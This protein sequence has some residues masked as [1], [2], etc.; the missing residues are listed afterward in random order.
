VPQQS[1]VIPGKGVAPLA[2]ILERIVG[3]IIDGLIVGIP[4]LIVY[5]IV[6]A[7]FLTS[8][9]SQITVD[10]VTGEI[11]SLGTAGPGFFVTWLLLFLIIF[12]AQIL[13][14]VGLI[15]TR[16]QTVGGMIMKIR[17]VRV[18]DGGLPGW[19]PAFKKWLL[20]ALVSLIPCVGGLASLAVYF[21][22][23]WDNNKRMQG[24]QDKWA[25]L[26]VVKDGPQF[27]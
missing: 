23:L 3:F 16:G 6:A 9:S 24:Y 5:W 21:S 8:T 14:V 1:V 26:Y 10:P 27:R 15:A 7:V 18:N 22:P 11:T 12:A 13:Y 25:E 19:G 2:S 17:A 4:A 20:P